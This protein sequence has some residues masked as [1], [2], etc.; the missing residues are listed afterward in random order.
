RQLEYHHGY[1]QWLFPL[2][3][4]GL[5]ISAEPLQKHEIESISKDE[6]ALKRLLES[7]K[8][9]LDFYGFKLVDENTGELRRLSGDSYK[10][11]FRNLDTSSHNYLRITRILKC[12][13]EFKYE[14]LKFPFLAA[15]LRESIT[16]NK[17]SNCLRSCKDYWIETLRSPDERRAIR[18]YAR[19]LVE[20]R[21]KG[22]TPPK[23]HKAH[24][25]QSTSAAAE[26]TE[27]MSSAKGDDDDHME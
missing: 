3:E 21:N 11:R 19:E 17:L 9:M 14:Y 25:P 13:G 27:N 24:R 26:E 4:R 1:I 16:E 6:K 5:N 7:Y 12:L 15:I 10:S 18:Q 23:T 20:Y 22:M 2:Q 8:L